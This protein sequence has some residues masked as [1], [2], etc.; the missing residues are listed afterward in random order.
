MNTDVEGGWVCVCCFL[1][2]DLILIL[3]IS[4]STARTDSVS[5]WCF[6]VEQLQN[7]KGCESNIRVISDVKVFSSILCYQMHRIW[8]QITHHTPEVL[9]VLHILL[10]LKCS[11]MKSI[12][13]SSAL[14]YCPLLQISSQG[15]F[16][17]KSSQ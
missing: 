8:S 5:V 14:T 3:D 13:P 17:L 7:A 12:P 4:A 2:G 11:Q 16:I 9:Q 15:A 1:H 10:S 6:Y